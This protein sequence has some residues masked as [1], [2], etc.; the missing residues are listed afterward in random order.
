M[1]RIGQFLGAI[2]SDWAARMSGP[3]TVPLTIAAFYVSSATYKRLWGIL[4]LLCA[5]FTT[6][7]V[8]L[9]ERK[10]YEQVVAARNIKAAWQAMQ[11]RFDEGYYP[12]SVYAGW[13]K[14]LHDE[15]I[16]RL[17]WW[18]GGARDQ[19]QTEQLLAVMEEAGSLI[20]N[21][22]FVQSKFPNMRSI[23]DAADR[24]LTAILIIN[25]PKNGIT[26]RAI[27]HGVETESGQLNDVLRRCVVLCSQLAAKESA[28]FEQVAAG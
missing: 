9:N 10:R 28:V 3:A 12:V 14:K 6:Y 2:F 26:G 13:E 27:D 18:V 25:R 8:W 21:S 17:K 24:W 20:L 5:L 1:H 11:N 23:S 16:T 22:A 19:L 15:D 4:A 7:R